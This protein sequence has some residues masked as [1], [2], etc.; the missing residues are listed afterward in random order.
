[1]TEDT[2]TS[3]RVAGQNPLDSKTISTSLNV[4]MAEISS[5]PSLYHSFYKGMKIYLQEEGE[6][7]IW[8]E[9]T[10]ANESDGILDENFTYPNSTVYQGFNYSGK[11]FNFIYT[12][13]IG[14]IR[15]NYGPTTI[16][17]DINPQ[18]YL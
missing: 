13:M 7:I 16:T 14:N 9:I 15:G 18:D 10:E 5:N 6:E 1:M 3:Y 11:E 8:T 12:R 17:P 4:L 2:S